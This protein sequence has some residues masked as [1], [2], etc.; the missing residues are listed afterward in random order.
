MKKEYILILYGVIAIVVIIF[1]SAILKKLGIFKSK[2]KKEQIQNVAELQG[3]DYFNPDYY[4]GKTIK[5][6]GSELA[7]EL[8]K[9]I[10]K[11]IKGAGTNENLLYDVFNRIYNKANISEIAE[12]YQ[13]KYNDSMKADILN[14]LKDKEKSMLMEIINSK[15]DR[16]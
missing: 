12:Q 7:K 2:E 5:P 13:L 8:C 3:A 6:L 10:R 1:L 16:T 15:P 4:K 14:D 11:A 9:E